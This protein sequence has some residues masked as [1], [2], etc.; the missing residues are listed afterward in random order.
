MYKLRPVCWILWGYLINIGVGEKQPRLYLACGDGKRQLLGLWCLRA[1]PPYIHQSISRFCEPIHSRIYSRPYMHVLTWQRR[2]TV[3]SFCQAVT[4]RSSFHQHA[5]KMVSICVL[6]CNIE[7]LDPHW[8]YILTSI[9]VWLLNL[10]TNL[11]F[12]LLINYNY[13]TVNYLIELW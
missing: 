4:T 9:Y 2:L 1:L 7:W 8:E 12:T 3:I 10:H 13:H 5:I 11:P 6:M